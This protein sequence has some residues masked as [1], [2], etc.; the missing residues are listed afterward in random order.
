MSV[1]GNAS[2]SPRIIDFYENTT[3]Y[4]LI[5]SVKWHSWIKPFAFIYAFMSQKTQQINLPL[6]ARKVEMTGDVLALH[7][8]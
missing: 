1:Y 5:S 8:G 2:L 6:H 3:D 4:Q 7:D